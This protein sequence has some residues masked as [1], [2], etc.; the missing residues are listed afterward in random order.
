MKIHNKILYFLVIFCC[1]WFQQ[2]TVNAQTPGGTSLEIELWSC[3]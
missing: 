2:Y 1:I 3:L